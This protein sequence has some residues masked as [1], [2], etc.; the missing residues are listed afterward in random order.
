MIFQFSSVCNKSF[1]TR[2][3]KTPVLKLELY[4]LPF[5]L[6]NEKRA[7]APSRKKFSSVLSNHVCLPLLE[8]KSEGVPME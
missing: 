7:Q 5:L 4:W 6:L 8:L 1:R 2:E 3:F